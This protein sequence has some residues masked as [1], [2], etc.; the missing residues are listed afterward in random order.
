MKLKSIGILVVAIV[1]SISSF[2][3]KEKM[4]REDKDE[5]N[6]ARETRINKKNDIVLFRKQ[7]MGLP[8]Y[9]KEKKKIPALQ[10]NNKGAV[11]VAAAIDSNEND[12][13]A[14]TFIGY[15]RQDVGDNSTN[16][17]EVIFDRAVRK[18]VSVKLTPEGADANK[19]EMDE[20]EDNVKEKQ[21]GVKKV[22]PK[23]NKD[24]DDDDDAP[25]DKPL[26]TKQKDDD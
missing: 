5:K 19:D 14:K 18:I 23:K 3:Q 24:E 17:Y 16:M 2:A 22:S 13:D 8:E 6:A 10:K 9:A 25:E 15:I 12:D 21:P 20:K 11:K 7:M 1:M 4:T 26:K